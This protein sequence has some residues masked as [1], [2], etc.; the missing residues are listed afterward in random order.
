MT[1]H[2]FKEWMDFQRRVMLSKGL[3]NR[4]R[5]ILACWLTLRENE[6]MT[7]AQRRAIIAERLG[8]RGSEVD[9]AF[10]RAAHA[11]LIHW[12]KGGTHLREVQELPRFEA[13]TIVWLLERP[14]LR[15]IFLGYAFGRGVGPRMVFR[16]DMEPQRSWV[17]RG[18]RVIFGKPHWCHAKDLG[19]EV[20]SHTL[21]W[22]GSPP[23][24]VWRRYDGREVRLL[25]EDAPA[26]EGAVQVAYEKV[27][28]GRVW[29]K[30]AVDFY[31]EY[32][33]VVD[34]AVLDR[35]RSEPTPRAEDIMPL[36]LV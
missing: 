23:D 5:L 36:R 2:S 4:D 6:R 1:V 29:R 26:S 11:K 7:A 13:G 22:H 19:G 18:G 10:K 24:L 15:Y 16:S 32:R 20:S 17:G 30:K 27:E 28:G 35:L 14:Q 21:P 25:S 34:E 3:V 33:P 8:V 31:C 12:G 9:L